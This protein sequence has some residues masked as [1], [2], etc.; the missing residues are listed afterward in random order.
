MTFTQQYFVEKSQRIPVAREVDVVV[1]GGGPA[2]LAAAI[3]AARNGVEV[4]LVERNSFLGGVPTA[5]LVPVF[6]IPVDR[7]SGFSKELVE[8]LV[9]QGGAW[10]DRVVSFDPE[11]FKQVALDMVDE[12]NVSLMLYTSAVKSIIE[13][14]LVKGVVTE[15]KSGRQAVVGN[16]VVD[17]TGDADL[18]FR[19]GLECVKGREK[20]GKMRPMTVVFRIGGVDVEK[21]V[22]YAKKHPEQFTPDPNT[23]I[24]E[25]K[26][27]VVRIHGFF[28]LVA[29]ARERGELDKDCHYL[30]L[31]GVQAN[32]GIAF[33]NTTRVYGVDGTDVFDITRAEM[34]AREQIKQLMSF[35]KKY[36]PGC[37]S[38]YLIDTST[39][40]GV[41]ETR[42]I[43][44]EYILTEND[45][46]THKNHEDAIVTL[47]RRHKPGTPLHSPDANEGSPKDARTRRIILPLYPFQIPFRCLLPTNVR[48]LIVAGRCISATHEADAFTRGMFCCMA[49]GQAAGTAA[50]L[51]AK[52]KVALKNI[53]IKK[54]QQALV[55]QRV[56]I[57]K[58]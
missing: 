24:L 43:K 18:T 13:N 29:K 40:I 49:T 6:V 54:L 7:L 15:S 20:D 51:S 16:V 50:A 44:G 4:L 33:V 46:A 3:S 31:E 55:K 57:E 17:A 28:D 22:E 38:S 52:N 56:N 10:I 36:I 39:S 47:W 41:R 27:K 35:I 34:K 25:L 8:R 53:S 9:S 5:T 21:V 23:Q 2:G 37:K 42:R 32:R 11:V 30:R 1:V 19:A 12:L 45:I 26:K 14:G 58:I 48:N